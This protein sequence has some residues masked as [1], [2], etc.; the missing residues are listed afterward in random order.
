MV[1]DPP[2]WIDQFKIQSGADLDFIIGEAYN[3]PVGLRSDYPAELKKRISAALT[4]Y[5]L[6]LKS[7]NYTR[8]NCIDNS[9]RKD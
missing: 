1:A 8:G 9:F 7:I 5:F 4:S 2:D 3:F 6:Q